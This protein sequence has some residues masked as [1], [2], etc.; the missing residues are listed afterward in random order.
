MELAAKSW[1]QK[2]IF[3]IPTQTLKHYLH[4]SYVLISHSTLD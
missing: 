4:G 3:G 2:I 1:Y